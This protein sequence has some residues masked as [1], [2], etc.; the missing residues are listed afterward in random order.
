MAE[1]AR[2]PYELVR[3]CFLLNEE[4]DFSCFDGTQGNNMDIHAVPF[5]KR[6][7]D[8]TSCGLVALQL[9]IELV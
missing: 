9:E 8:E 2:R 5:V 1:E 3:H 4:G 7:P 6:I